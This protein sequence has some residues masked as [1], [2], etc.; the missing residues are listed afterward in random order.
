MLPPWWGRPAGSGGQ[1]A[2]LG[3]HRLGRWVVGVGGAVGASDGG[4][5]GDLA[6]L[7]ECARTI[8]AG[9]LRSEAGDLAGVA[10]QSFEHGQDGQG[11]GG[12]D[13]LGD[14]IGVGVGDVAAD[15][16]EG[17]GD[18]QQPA[19]AGALGAAAGRLMMRNMP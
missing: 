12:G 16:G 13:G 18:D 10:L 6:G 19:V 2:P 11:D 14:Q 8:Q 3:G 7:R 5:V 4:G 17:A 9:G 1:C 15:R